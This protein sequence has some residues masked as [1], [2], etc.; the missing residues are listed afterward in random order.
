MKMS[1]SIVDGGDFERK[2]VLQKVIFHCWSEE[3]VDSLEEE[4][5]GDPGFNVYPPHDLQLLLPDS[6][7]LERS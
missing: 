5:P 4:L 3:K 1:R 2:I 6:M 7:L